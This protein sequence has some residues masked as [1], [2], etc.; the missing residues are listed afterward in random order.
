MLSFRPVADHE[1]VPCG[2]R[3][4]TNQ[5]RVCLVDRAYFEDRPRSSA[6]EVKAALCEVTNLLHNSRRASSSS[7][8]DI[9]YDHRC[10][11]YIRTLCQSIRRARLDRRGIELVLAES[12]LQLDSEKLEA[13]HDRL[14]IDHQLCAACFRRPRRKIRIEL[15]SF[16]PFAQCSFMDNRSSRHSS[17]PVKD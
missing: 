16:G 8:A 1:R 11:S 9:Q 12:P 14:R 3:T 13:R 5:Q 17:A 2:S 10:I 15:S 7:N 6:G 4:R